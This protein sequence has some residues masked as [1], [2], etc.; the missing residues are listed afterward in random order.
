MRVSP[1]HT[2]LAPERTTAN[3][4]T[5]LANLI[6]NPFQE[7]KL[8]IISKSISYDKDNVC[9]CLA[10]AQLQLTYANKPMETMHG[11]VMC[12]DDVQNELSCK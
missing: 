2:Y 8:I 3:L 11:C 12:D 7:L 4:A 9:T 6:S 5:Q 10:L 1:C